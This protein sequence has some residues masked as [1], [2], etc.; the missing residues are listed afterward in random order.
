MNHDQVQYDNHTG[1][2]KRFPQSITPISQNQHFVLWKT[3]IEYYWRLERK[4]NPQI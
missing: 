1:Q 4:K 2:L 3:D